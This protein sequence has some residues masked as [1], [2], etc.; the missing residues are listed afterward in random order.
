MDE[1]NVSDGAFLHPKTVVALL[2]PR[3]EEGRVGCID[4]LQGVQETWL[5]AGFGN[6]DGHL[7]PTLNGAE[8]DIGI[9][10]SSVLGH[11]RDAFEDA[12]LD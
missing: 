6:T 11:I 4:S 7:R 8:A 5:I 12:F 10:V 2:T 9:T 1:L 3:G